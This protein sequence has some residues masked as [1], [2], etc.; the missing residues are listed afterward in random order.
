MPAYVDT[1]LNIVHVNDVAAG[2]LLAFEKGN[3][4]ERYVLGGENMALKDILTEISR[5]VGSKPPKIS[6]PHSLVMPFAYLAEVWVRMSGGQEPFA[7]VDGI[8]MARKKMYFSSAK[9]IRTLDY[10]PRPAKQALTDAIK[11]FSANGYCP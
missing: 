1:G 2:H 6:L 5:L 11:W 3:I 4:G 8:R 9:A 7:T 10:R